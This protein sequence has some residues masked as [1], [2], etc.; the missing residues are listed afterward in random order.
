MRIGL[1]QVDGKWPNL[2]LMKLSTWHK[3]QGDT[4]EMFLPLS[5]HDKVYASKVFDFARWVN[6]KA[7]FKTVEWAQYGKAV[8]Q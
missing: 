2:A 3:Q 8:T 1:C 4:V 6:H 7:I 5:E